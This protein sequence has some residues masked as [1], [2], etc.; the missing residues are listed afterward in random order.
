M[1]EKEEEKDTYQ[2]EKMES[3]TNGDGTMTNTVGH[4][5]LISN[6]PVTHASTLRTQ[7]IIKLKQQQRI[8][9]ADPLGTYTSAIDGVGGVTKL[10]VY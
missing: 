6:I 4:V 3:E 7:Q 1:E 2:M 9:W 5:V 8:P 10:L